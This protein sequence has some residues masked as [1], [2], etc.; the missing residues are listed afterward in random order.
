MAT[1]NTATPEIIRL[2]SIG[3]IIKVNSVNLDGAISFGDLGGAPTMIDATCLTDKVQVNILGVQ[4]QDAW[5][6]EYLYNSKSYAQI[7]ALAADATKS[8]PVSITFPDGS[9]FSN[10]GKISNYMS[11][12]GNGETLT[13]T[14]SV[15]LDGKWT[16]A[17]GTGTVSGS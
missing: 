6:V 4:K 16:F 5:A 7:D 17:A 3:V 12:K 13:A 2:S 11:G 1:T 8:Y 15:A 9:T 10:T 14:M